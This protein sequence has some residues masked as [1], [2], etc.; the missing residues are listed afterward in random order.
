MSE[1]RTMRTLPMLALIIPLS[2]C[3]NGLFSKGEDYK[4]P[5][6]EKQRYLMREARAIENVP[7][8]VD[9]FP[10]IETAAK[11]C[12]EKKKEAE[13]STCRLAFIAAARQEIR[14]RFP[15]VDPIQGERWFQEEHQ[16]EAGAPET[17]DSDG[18]MG[19]MRDYEEGYRVAY[20]LDRS[21][22]RLDRDRAVAREEAAHDAAVW[23]A[24]GQSIQ[25][26]QQ[27]NTLNRIDQNT[28]PRGY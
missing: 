22:A 15:S 10:E 2:A 17:P 9:S 11:R 13:K 18:L 14:G 19:L 3:S 26:Q 4:R 8:V 7:Y 16:S 23:A 6:S 20:A 24:I 28:R 5:P 12:F 21:G 1:N 25:M 27:Q